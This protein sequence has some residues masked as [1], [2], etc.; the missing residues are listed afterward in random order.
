VGI[1]GTHPPND[2]RA[3]FLLEN[4]ASAKTHRGFSNLQQYLA[5][6]RRAGITLLR[7]EVLKE[8]GQYFDSI[9]VLIGLQKYS[10][11]DR[12]EEIDS[13]FSKNI[14]YVVADIRTFINSLPISKI[15][16]QQFRK[17]TD[18]V[19]ESLRKTNLLRQVM[20]FVREPDLLFSV[21][22]AIQRKPKTIRKSRLK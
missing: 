16:G 18:L 8:C 2:L 21:P 4:N 19:S 11:S 14:P 10:H 6:R 3:A 12:S 1:S 9:L 13:S 17:F 7:S 22:P 15:D 20:P 5:L